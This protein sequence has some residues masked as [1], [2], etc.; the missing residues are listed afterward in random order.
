MPYGMSAQSLQTYRTV[1]MAGTLVKMP[2]GRRGSLLQALLG[3]TGW[4]S[5]VFRMQAT[6]LE[7]DCPDQGLATGE[8]VR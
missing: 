7:G 3:V 5:S 2:A 1:P 4:E 6:A 8:G